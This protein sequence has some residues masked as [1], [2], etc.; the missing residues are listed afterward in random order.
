M[1][2]RQARPAR[3][4]PHGERKKSHAIS[5]PWPYD[6]HDRSKYSLEQI[7]MEFIMWDS[8]FE[9][10]D[11]DRCRRIMLTIVYNSPRSQW[12]ARFREFP[13]PYEKALQDERSSLA[14]SPADIQSARPL[15]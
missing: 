12:E 15:A 8:P 6:T 13:R 9:W 4:R 10:W 3:Q 7:A 5:P 11:V 14:A 1:A 2:P